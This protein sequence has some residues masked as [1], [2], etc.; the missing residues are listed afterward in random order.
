MKLQ[1]ITML[2]G[3]IV[4]GT[5]PTVAPPAPKLVSTSPAFW[6]VGVNAAAQKNISL[7]FDQPMSPAFSAWL[8]RS[9]VAPEIDLN[10]SMTTDRKGISTPVKLQAGR[11]YV[12]ALNEKKIPGVGFQNDKGI[13]APPY[14]LVFQT[15]GTP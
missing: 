6:S 7:T 11:V 1:L 13:S 4:A 15:S 12:L 9:S 5:S 3:A 8:G 14:Y 10:S 2:F